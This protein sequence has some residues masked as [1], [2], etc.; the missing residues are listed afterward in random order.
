MKFVAVFLL[1]FVFVG[2]QSP[3][4]RAALTEEQATSLAEKLASDKIY[5]WSQAPE[6]HPKADL[7]D[8]RWIWKTVRRNYHGDYSVTVGLAVDGST[9]SVDIKFLPG[10]LP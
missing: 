7:V 4:T 10:G 2:C 1:A 3:P 6:L 8:G 9:N 5:N